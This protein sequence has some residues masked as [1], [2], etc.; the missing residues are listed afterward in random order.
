MRKYGEYFKAERKARDL[1]QAQLA[2]AI[3]ISQQAV[4]FYENDTNEPS[5]SI[6]E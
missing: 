1:T 3:G 5:I 6:C 2:E 4:S